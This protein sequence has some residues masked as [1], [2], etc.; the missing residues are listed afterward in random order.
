MLYIMGEDGIGSLV[1]PLVE[2]IKAA[3]EQ[4]SDW[5]GEGPRVGSWLLRRDG[6]VL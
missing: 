6:R 1:C 2:S 4:Q 5:G 3:P